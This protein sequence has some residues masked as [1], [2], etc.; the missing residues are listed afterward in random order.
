MKHELSF[1]KNQ[2]N[3]QKIQEKNLKQNLAIKEKEI[4]ELKTI[5][6][7]NVSMKS[8]ISSIYKDQKDEENSKENEKERE[9]EICSYTDNNNHN[10][11][12]LNIGKKKRKNKSLS[13]I[14]RK[15][16]SYSNMNRRNLLRVN[17]INK[18]NNSKNN[19][20]RKNSY[21]KNKNKNKN[22]NGNN[23][24]NIGNN[25]IANSEYKYKTIANVYNSDSSTKRTKNDN[26]I[27]IKHKIK[28][29]CYYNYNSI[30][31]LRL[32]RLDKSVSRSMPSKRGIEE[33][34]T[35]NYFLNINRSD[36]SS[37]K[38][39]KFMKDKNVIK[40]KILINYNTN[41]IN[42]NISID[43]GS[44][45]KKIKE[46]KNS[47]EEK[48]SDIARNKNKKNGI[49]RTISAFYDKRDKNTIF[50][51]KIKTRRERSFRRK[52]F[53]NFDKNNSSKIKKNKSII[54]NGNYNTNNG[55][56]S[57]LFRKQFP[58]LI[59]Q[60]KNKN[61]KKGK[62]M[63]IKLKDNSMFNIKNDMSKD[64]TKNKFS[65]IH[66]NTGKNP[67]NEKNNN[68]IIKNSPTVYINKNIISIKKHHN[69]PNYETNVNRTLKNN[70][71]NVGLTYRKYKHF[72]N[73]S[74]FYDKNFSKN[75]NKGNINKLHINSSTN[76]LNPS[77]RKFIFSKC[78]TNS[79]I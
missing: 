38:N 75:D 49:K 57:N 31:T 23:N 16:S 25:L 69:Y 36:I 28:K 78:M 7:T 39:K 30:N 54:V 15:L 46:L 68:K 76:R 66:A 60:H 71:Y 4:N 43:K 11:N 17:Y 59:I 2:K 12:S 6:N 35:K 52:N 55:N 27:K 41:I 79:N 48:I 9:K 33:S 26:S 47:L 8:Q 44:L 10:F 58:Q 14:E 65:I 62:K 51:E 21:K 53:Y 19:S 13:L 50:I 20:K 24:S 45:N 22:L 73:M 37:N 56:N 72:D 77:L 67:K 1:L 29:S 3:S 42:T 5:L 61:A 70:P 64:Y 40:N 34:F 32:K 63:T 74:N 18:S